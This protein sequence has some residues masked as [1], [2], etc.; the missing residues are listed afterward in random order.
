M[1]SK[2]TREKPGRKKPPLAKLLLD[3]MKVKSLGALQG[4]GMSNSIK[5]LD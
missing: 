4:M 1:A 5:A 2:I 3:D